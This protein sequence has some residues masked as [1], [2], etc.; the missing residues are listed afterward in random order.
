MSAIEPI[1]EKARKLAFDV[2]LE[3]VRKWKAQNPGRLAVGYMPIYVP[4]PLIEAIGALPVAMFGGGDQI[5]IIRG[6][7]FYQSYICH[8][9]RSTLELA[10]TGHLDVLDGAIFPSICD[11]IRNLSGMWQMLFPNKY[12]TY[13]DLPQSFDPALGGRFYI[14][15]MKR[16][17]R[18][19]GARGAMPLEESRLREAIIRENERRAALEELDLLREKEPW[20]VRASEAYVIARA[21][22][23]LDTV[24]HTALVRE[25]VKAAR[26]RETRVYDNVRVVVRGSFCEQPPM[27]LIRT[28]EAAGCDIVDDDFQLGLRFIEGAIRETGDPVEALSAAYLQHGTATSSRY[29]GTEEKGAALV[30]RVHDTHAEG[31]VFAAASFCDPALLDQPMLEAALDRA[32]IPHTSLKFS[33]NSAQFQVVREQAGAFSDA[34]KLWGGAA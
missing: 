24:A 5:D 12:S 27:G 19:L 8:I 31:V 14:A 22:S 18:E 29:I 10:L 34:V 28:L 26:D 13:L 17:A 6:D 33:E 15:E 11:V 20:R 32:K 1:L 2:E 23:V 30:K 9:P 16:I 4:R 3:E 25:F 21:G 7:S